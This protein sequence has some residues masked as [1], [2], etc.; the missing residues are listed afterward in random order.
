MFSE[1]APVSTMTWM[2]NFIKED[3]QTVD[4]WWLLDISAEHS[5]NGYSSEK[6]N[7]WNSNG[8]LAITGH[9]NIAQFY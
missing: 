1:I 9:Q 2:M 7:V 3:P 5:R 8:E 6:F 4:G